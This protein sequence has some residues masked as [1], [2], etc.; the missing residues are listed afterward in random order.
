MSIGDRVKVRRTN[1]TR[2]A[3]WAGLSGTVVNVKAYRK[4]EVGVALIIRT[5][6]G[7]TITVFETAAEVRARAYA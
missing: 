7:R 1:A 5:D 6:C 3:G 2:A 4:P